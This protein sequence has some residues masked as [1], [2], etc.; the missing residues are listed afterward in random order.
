MAW[1]T[2]QDYNEALQNP[3]L[4]LTDSELR[5]GS[6][7][8]TPL[9]L[10]RAISGGFASVY[11][12]HSGGRDWAVR[13]FLR[14]VPDQ[15][16]RYAAIGRHLAAAKLSSTVGFAFLPDGISVAGQSYPIL[17]MEW[18][19]G[20]PLERWIERHLGDPAALGRLAERWVALIG[21]LRA[22]RVAHGDL[23]HGNILIVNDA[24]R[25]IDYDGM[26]VPALAGRP[27]NEV[28]H[29]NYQHP[30][31]GPG[32]FGPGID[33]FA[34][35]SIAVSLRAL[36]LQPALWSQLGAGDEALLLRRE[37]Y[38]Q[39]ASSA[40][41]RA[42]NGIAAPDFRALLGQFRALLDQPVAALPLLPGTTPAAPPARTVARRRRAAPAPVV[43]RPAP[44]T[45]AAA[46]LGD[47]LVPPPLVAL[48]AAQRPARATGAI[49]LGLLF[50]I[51][52]SATGRL[53]P[54]TVATLAGG[55]VIVCGA[56]ALGVS[57]LAL[58]IV[59]RALAA[60]AR[61]WRLDRHLQTLDRAS[62]RLEVRLAQI[63][64]RE[65]DL[66]EALG[67]RRQAVLREI[68]EARAAIDRALARFAVERELLDNAEV[69]ALAAAL[70]DLRHRHAAAHLAAYS[71]L[72]AAIPG[73]G[74][75]LKLRLLAAGIRTAAQ[76]RD[77]HIAAVGGGGG[78][79]IQI[80]VPGRGL[81]RVEGLGRK[82]AEA[83]LSWRQLLETQAVAAL[84]DQLT[85][86]EDAAIRLRFHTRREQLTRRE[87][88]TERAAIRRKERL[89]TRVRDERARFEREAATIRAQAVA[90]RERVNADLDANQAALAAAHLALALARRDLAAYAPI[91]FARYARLVIGW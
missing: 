6:P 62:R 32:D 3:H 8:L 76:V 13:C 67:A 36:A 5:A 4:N 55:V 9:G 49:V 46:W 61:V 54:L 91:R 64:A 88:A 60:R 44:P 65:A 85:P 35:W 40:A 11:R 1:P 75:Q 73:L 17:K 50:L 81:V 78:E 34:A 72:T 28:G 84:P 68:R 56:V 79:L 41:F 33:T 74:T 71:V 12:L 26:Y 58:P 77:L 48:P 42:L 14:E 39:P 80:D 43:A 66:L 82:K 10:P 30:R 16:E 86:G 59:R 31:R 2:P 22:A 27:G 70:R 37:D 20:E 18:V 83:L 24:P 90:P 23:Q 63:D 57:Y 89:Q 25:L 29:R 53:L 47:H 52:I 38:E 19:G 51:L 87:A 45:G 21:S 7:E 15:Q 69:E